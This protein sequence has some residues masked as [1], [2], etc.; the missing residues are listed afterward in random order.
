MRSLLYN[1]GGRN[2][3]MKPVRST[4]NQYIGINAHLHSL[5]QA[6]GGW[7]EFHAA[8]IIYLANSLKVP[9]LPRGY[10]AIEALRT[11]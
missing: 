8:H 2:K 3:V 1:G 7:D 4:K 11:A 5:W 10:T 9:L 6:E